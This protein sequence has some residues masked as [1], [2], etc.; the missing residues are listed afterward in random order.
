[1]LAL[2]PVIVAVALSVAVIV[3]DVAVL[4]VIV[5]TLIPASELWKV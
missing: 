1:M 3:L 4:S 5:K 2:V